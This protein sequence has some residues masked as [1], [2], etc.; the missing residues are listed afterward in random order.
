MTSRYW[1]F[2]RSTAFV[3]S[4]FLVP[5]CIGVALWLD[6]LD[7]EG[8]FE[9]SGW[10]L[11]GAIVVGLLPVL[12]VV[13]GGVRS[14]EA[15]GVKVAFAAVQDVVSK[16]TVDARTRLA[17]NLGQPPGQVYDEKGDSII[18]LLNDAVGNDVVVV[19]LKE[20]KAWWETRLLLLAA[21]ATRLGH[22][23]A[24]V[25]TA[26]KPGRPVAFV[27][28]AAPAGMLRRLLASD[29][30]LRDAYDQ[31]QRDAML[32]RLSSQHVPTAQR[33]LPWASAGKATEYVQPGSKLPQL[34]QPS[35]NE[36][37]VEFP[38]PSP[39]AQGP[40]QPHQDDDF[41]AERF[42]LATFGPLETE[43]AL[44]TL[45]EMRVKDL[46]GSILHTDAVDRADNEEQ[47]IATI[48]GST[49]DYFAV[50]AG[51]QFVNLV[52]RE[53]AVNAVLGALVSGL[54]GER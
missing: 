9:I 47:W 23:R 32:W 50:T 6:R 44:R 34:G 29:H 7:G 45:S 11:L 5:A 18:A 22:P 27:G 16:T 10:I 36:N 26:A 31:A 53:A 43:D 54:A 40:L 25:F 52:P 24:I 19:D 20:G 28:W 39:N 48:V 8:G 4:V 17:N 2:R 21:G 38:W 30:Q 14:V 15:G 46:F 13:L 33:L 12:L 37:F 35:E 1:P 49:A 41:A 3:W 51:G 42:L